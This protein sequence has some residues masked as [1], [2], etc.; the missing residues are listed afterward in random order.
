[1]GDGVG[2]RDVEVLLGE[3]GAGCGCRE[4]V[5]GVG[6]GYGE[7]KWVW[8]VGAGCWVWGVRAGC[9]E[10]VLGVGNGCWVLGDYAM[11]SRK[12]YTLFT[13]YLSTSESS[14]K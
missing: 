5:L 1:M 12:L 13:Y 11:S 2:A 9:W 14:G 8:G 7:W 4:W 3:L 10:W 6:A